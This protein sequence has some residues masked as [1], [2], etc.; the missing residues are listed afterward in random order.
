MKPKI[1]DK[2]IYPDGREVV[3]KPEEIRR[4]IKESVS[5]TVIDM[6]YD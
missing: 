1:I 5:K 2:I 3:Y 6:M 4:V